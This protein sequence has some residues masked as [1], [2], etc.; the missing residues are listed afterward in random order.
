MDKKFIEISSEGM[1]TITEKEFLQQEQK[2]AG[3][4]LLVS[5][6]PLLSSFNYSEK[7]DIFIDA[8]S[9]SQRC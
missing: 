8:K 7:D 9:D 4:T 1:R 3:G 6:I 5:P 2:Y